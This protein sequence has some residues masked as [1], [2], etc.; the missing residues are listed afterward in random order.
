MPLY[1]CSW[2]RMRRATHEALTKRVVQNYH[3][4]QTKEAT[5]LSSSLLS[6]SATPNLEKH[7]HRSA[8]ST[9]LSILYD[10]PTL[11]SIHDPTLE[12]IEEYILRTSHA[13]IPGTYFVDIFPW[14][15]YI[16]ERSGITFHHLTLFMLTHDTTKIREM[17]ARRPSTIHPGFC[18]V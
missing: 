6:P 18:Y 8:A 15:M 3:P 13:A 17:E 12:K 4:L 2:R 11:K 16:P 14:M 1:S 5:I 7:F 9:I 10:Y